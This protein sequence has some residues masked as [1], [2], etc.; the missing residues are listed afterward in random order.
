[1]D[2]IRIVPRKLSRL[3]VF[4][5]EDATYTDSGAAGSDLSGGTIYAKSDNVDTNYGN[6]KR[7]YFLF[8]NPIDLPQGNAAHLLFQSSLV[9]A[10][11]SGH[12]ARNPGLEVLARLRLITNLAGLDKTTLNWSNQGTLTIVASSAGNDFAAF[13]MNSLDAP[14]VPPYVGKCKT[15]SSIGHGLLSFAPATAAQIYGAVFESQHLPVFPN[16]SASHEFT[17][18]KR[19]YLDSECYGLL[20]FGPTS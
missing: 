19:Q 13:A 12:D 3:R 14:V 8:P 5:I 10:F 4:E 17:I 1:M 16:E 7:A 9:S 11:G 20:F 15:R 18:P 6:V 2:P